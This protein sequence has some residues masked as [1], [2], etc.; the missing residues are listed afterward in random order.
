MLPGDEARAL[1]I[2]AVHRRIVRL[3][4]VHH[5]IE[6]RRPNGRLR[7]RR[8]LVEA[9]SGAWSLPEADLA[10][11]VATSLV[12]PPAWLNPEL[13]DHEGRR[14]T[15]PDL[16]LDDVAMAIMVHSRE[17]HAGVLDWET[18]VD[19]DG[20][21]AASRV[22][23]IGVTPGSLARDPDGVLRRI[24]A[25]YETARRSGLRAAVVATPRIVPIG[26][27]IGAVEPSSSTFVSPATRSS[28]QR[29]PVTSPV[30]SP[31]ISREV[32]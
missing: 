1:L 27:L 28:S 12:L 22:V 16:W 19:R 14:L 6:A 15:T 21:L 4:D 5:W 7:L 30:T 29:A 3:D 32:S 18:T 24:E 23:V 8:A 9:A 13:R 2:D 25:A 20:D 31:V 11:L 10:R 17:F 26:H